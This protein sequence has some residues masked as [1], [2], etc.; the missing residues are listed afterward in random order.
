MSEGSD[1]G[2]EKS[3]E[4]TQ[5]RIADARRKGDVAKSTDLSAAAAY[6]GLL[7]ALFIAGAGSAKVAGGAMSVFIGQTDRLEGRILGPG[8]AQ[9]SAALVGEVA[10]GLAPFF[11][12]PF[13][14]ALAILLAQQAFAF[15]PEKLAPKLSRISPI[16]NAKNKYGM[17][18][19]FEFAKSFVKMS[20]IAVVLYFFL[21]SEI[22]PI[23]GAIRAPAAQIPVEMLRLGIGM[24][25]MI[26]ALAIVIGA[27]DFMWQRFDHTRKLRM[28]FQELRDEN[29]EVEGD[30]HQKASR[31]RRAEEIARNQML[32][33]VPRSDVVIVNPTHYAVALT[34]SRQAGSA[35]ECVAKGVDDTAMAIRRVAEEAG[36][37][38]QSDPP[39][40][41][42][43]HDLVEIGQE[44]PPDLYRAVAAAI[45]FAEDMRGKARQ[46]GWDDR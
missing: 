5:K 31:R 19:L 32:A 36:V 29:K 24:L 28:T 30:P 2:A 26:C 33:D 40:A 37:P 1:D 25:A 3:H 41:R 7:T 6:L 44:V 34:W 22:N 12:L 42:A 45:R 21:V 39:T 27:I 20:V 15:A 43:L 9:L 16:S 14:L 8:G 10:A 38:I 4:P 35:P 17:T 11:I 23:I 18:G 13:M 46:T